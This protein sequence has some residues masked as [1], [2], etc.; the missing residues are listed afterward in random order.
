MRFGFRARLIGGFG[1]LLVLLSLVA[2]V[3][4]KGISDLRALTNQMTSSDVP[5][6]YYAD[7]TLSDLLGSR[8]SVLSFVL[9]EDDASRNQELAELQLARAQFEVDFEELSNIADGDQETILVQRIG[10]SWSEQDQLA[11]GIVDSAVNGPT[12]AA[13][14]LIPRFHEVADRTNEL[15]NEFVQKQ[16]S[17]TQAIERSVT[18]AY[19]R[20]QAQTLRATGLALV[21]G[22]ATAIFIGT[23]TTRAVQAVARAARQVAGGNLAVRALVTTGDELKVLADDFNTMAAGLERQEYDRGCAEAAL[24]DGEARYRH[25]ME[26]AGDG[27]MMVD[28]AGR[29][30]EANP[31][32]KELLG[33]EAD[34]LLG[35]RLRDLMVAADLATSRCAYPDRANRHRRA[36]NVA[37][38]WT[39]GSDRG[40]HHHSPGWR[41]D[42]HAPRHYPP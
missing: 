4:I 40:E 5:G 18:N 29:V 34:S 36:A 15:V 17:D 31:R 1:V 14:A 3:G 13:R 37:T 12:G 25:L 27:I 7:A 19:D 30:V 41:P 22:L 16:K 23:R 39:G 2:A 35:C 33:Y 26:Q 8:E 24:R 6:L 42:R 11:S 32:A 28:S 9:A 10:A 38:G 20:I 21:L